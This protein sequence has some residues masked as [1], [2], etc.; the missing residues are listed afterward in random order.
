MESFSTRWLFSWR[1]LPPE[2]GHR[3]LFPPC[4]NPKTKLFSGKGEKKTQKVLVVMK[5]A[6]NL[7][8]KTYKNII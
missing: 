5:K 7:Q 2:N 6:L 3:A 4:G 8:Q 1:L